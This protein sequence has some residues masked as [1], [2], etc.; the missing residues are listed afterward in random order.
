LSLEAVERMHSEVTH[1]DTEI[2]LSLRNNSS[3]IGLGLTIV[4]IS[5]ALTKDVSRDLT[6]LFINPL[7]G[8]VAVM[9]LLNTADV[10]VMAE[11]RDRMAHVLNLYF[12][13]PIVNA[14]LVSDIRRGS[15]ATMAI[16]ALLG[17]IFASAVLGS[18]GYAWSRWREGAL[19]QW[20]MPYF[21]LDSL[22]IAT[23]L[24]SVRSA[25]LEIAANRLESYRV[26]D[27]VFGLETRPD[28]IVSWD[29]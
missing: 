23:T 11:V 12:G 3:I 26:L 10:A 5:V 22:F 24:W 21:V 25:F 4:A 20:G 19:D 1:W 8:Y 14:R 18:C 16:N 6:V 29:R 28:S 27:E 17:L 9:H 13:Q 15:R 2:R 7:L